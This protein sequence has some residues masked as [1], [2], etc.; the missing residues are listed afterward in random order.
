MSRLSRFCLLYLRSI[1]LKSNNVGMCDHEH[2]CAH[3]AQ[4]APEVFRYDLHQAIDESKVRKVAH[5]V[6]KELYSVDC[7]ERSNG[8]QWG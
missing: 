7:V 1:D 4:E 3:E 5:F 2:S 6:S 8:R